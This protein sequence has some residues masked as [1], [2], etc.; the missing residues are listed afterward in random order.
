MR[1]TKIKTKEHYGE[2]PLSKVRMFIVHDNENVVTNFTKRNSR[3]QAVYRKEILPIVLPEY[4]LTGVKASWSQN[5]GCSCGCSPGFI[6]D[7][8]PAKTGYEV[9]WVHVK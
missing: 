4:L 8:H 7:V 3:P 5:A 2:R 1:I 6:L 9:M